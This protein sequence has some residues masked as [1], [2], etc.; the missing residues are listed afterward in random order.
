[1]SGAKSVKRSRKRR[2]EAL[3]RES[4][5]DLRAMIR[6]LLDRPMI[7]RTNFLRVRVPG[8]GSTL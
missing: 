6:R 2:L 4:E 5:R 8:G 7:E 3:R 1:M